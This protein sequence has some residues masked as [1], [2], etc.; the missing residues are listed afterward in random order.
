MLDLLQNLNEPQKKAVCHINGPLLILAGPG[1]GKTKVI[2]HRIANL[3]ANQIPGNKILALTFTNK[4]AGEMAERVKKLVGACGAWISTFHSFCARTLYQEAQHL[5]Y[6]PN[7]SIYDTDDQK[8][9]LQQAIFSYQNENSI[10]NNEIE[11]REVWNKISNYKNQGLTAEDATKI[12]GSSN[13]I[14][15]IYRHY[16]SSLK[17][18][19]AMDFDDLILN[20]LLLLNN[21]KEV[22]E[23]YQERFQYILLDEFQDTN[24]PQY[25]IAKKLAEKH[26]NICATGDPDQSIYS[27]RGADISNILE[28]ER[29]F[30]GTSVVKLEQNYRSTKYILQAA[31]EVIAN[32]SLRKEKSLW[33]QNSQ[34]LPIRLMQTWTPEEEAE[35]VANDIVRQHSQGIPYNHIVVFYRVNAQ[36][37]NLENSLTKFRIPYVLVGGLEFYDRMEI[38]DIMAYLRLVANKNDNLALLRIIAVPPRGIGG[39]TLEKF[40]AVSQDRGISLFDAMCDFSVRCQL[41]P[42]ARSSVQDFVE[43]IEKIRRYDNQDLNKLI[44]ELLVQSK[45]LAHIRASDISKEQSKEENINQFINFL[46]KHERETQNHSLSDFLQMLSLYSNAD[47]NNEDTDKVTLMTLHAAKGLEFP[48]VYMIGANEG[49][50]PHRYST[51]DEQ[52]EEERRLFFVGITRAQKLLTISYSQQI[53]NNRYMEYSPPSQFLSEIPEDAY[54]WFFHHSSRPPRLRAVEF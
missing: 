10:R 17:L 54:K 8:R 6:Q 42:R 13:S 22:L 49:Y 19:N 31:S 52:I 20:M 37:Q 12:A 7:F 21:Y 3:I 5:G 25:K 26:R 33:T 1:S 44:T 27:W 43:M 15:Y 16:Q 2:T 14:A 38:K 41:G 4:A 28:F 30:P 51:T 36:S 50:L 53:P 40:V 45:Y 35:R 9:A 46:T 24:I 11:L 29:D 48:V 32:N 23:R 47:E 18:N 34:G 39:K